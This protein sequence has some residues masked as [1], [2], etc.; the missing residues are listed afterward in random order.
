ML[1]IFL[2]VRFFQFSSSIMMY[3]KGVDKHLIDAG[4]MACPLL[5]EERHTQ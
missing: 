1:A 3:F 4:G 5:N 2:K